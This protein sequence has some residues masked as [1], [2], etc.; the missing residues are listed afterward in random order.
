MRLNYKLKGDSG[1]PLVIIHGLFGSLD[2]WQT[3]ANKLAETFKVYI[4]DLR[5][6]GKSPH[7][8]EHSYELMADDLK[9]FFG[10]H[11]LRKVNLIGHSMGGKTALLFADKYP[12]YLAKLMV[13]DIGVKGYPPHHTEI[14]Q[15]L[16]AIPQGELSSRKEADEI[17]VEY[18]PDFATRQFLLKNL[19]R[20][21]GKKLVWKM[22]L[23][24]LEEY[25]SEIGGELPINVIETETLFVRGERSNYILESDYKALEELLPNSQVVTAHGTGHWIHAEAPEFFYNKVIE[26]FND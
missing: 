5:N 3:L 10:E 23:P 21:E 26:F 1:E 6:H 16:N 19:T 22:N 18:V 8:N 15:G 2:N 7:S 17:L 4:V 13:V 11:S 25:I 12:E 9:L 20:D 14:L 24:V